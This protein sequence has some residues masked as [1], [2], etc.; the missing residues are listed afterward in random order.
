[1]GGLGSGKGT[2]F[3]AWRSKKRFVSSLPEL[4]IPDLIYMHKKNPDNKFLLNQVELRVGQSSIC[5]EHPENTSL[6]VSEFKISLL[7]CNYGGYRYYGLCPFCQKRVRSLYLYDKAALAC[8]LC[9]GM[10]YFSQNTT[11]SNRI[12]AKITS[13]RKKLYSNEQKKPKW[14][15]KRTF[16]KLRKVLFELNEKELIADYFSF[17]NYDSVNKVF[18]EFGSVLAAAEILGEQLYFS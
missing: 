4:V 6:E 16:E 2:R 14:M 13:I 1:M 8:R 12:Q 9:L 11:L 5:L 7:P 10:V 18:N 3:N 17:N 15:R